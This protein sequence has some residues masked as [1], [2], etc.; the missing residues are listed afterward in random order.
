VIT[1]AFAFVVFVVF[2]AFVVFV[3]FFAFVVF[4][5]VLLGCLVG[6]GFL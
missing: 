1:V 3:L 4:F 2:F 5:F 6:D